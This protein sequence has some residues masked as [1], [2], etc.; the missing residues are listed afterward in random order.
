MVFAPTDFMFTGKESL[1]KAPGLGYI[2]KKFHITVNRFSMEG[3]K[4]ALDKYYQALDQ[5]KSLVVYP[6]GGIYAKNPPQMAEFR[7]G[8]FTAAITKKIPIVPVTIPYNWM[9][10]PDDGKFLMRRRTIEVI[11]HEPIKT[12]HLSIKDIEPLK[13]TVYKIIQEELNLHNHEHRQG[14][15]KKDSALSKTGF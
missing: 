12:E 13:R 4:S 11:F 1:T 14:N 8:A 9:I 6:E 5:G 2:F 7:H 10:M 3:R 15:T